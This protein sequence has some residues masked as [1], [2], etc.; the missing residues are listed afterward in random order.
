[1][2]SA[3]VE[4][5]DFDLNWREDAMTEDRLVLAEILE[6]AGDGDFQTFCAP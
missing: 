6:K 2:R 3:K 1:V 4:L 5:Q